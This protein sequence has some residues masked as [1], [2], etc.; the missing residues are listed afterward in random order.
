MA[1]CDDFYSAYYALRIYSMS[2][3][4]E[5]KGS[6]IRGGERGGERERELLSAHCARP[7][8]AKVR[9]EKPVG[10]EGLKGATTKQSRDGSVVSVVGWTESA[11]S[12]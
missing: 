11:D 1:R 10:G 12:A 8:V 4:D 3:F 9:G 7:C 2:I 6:G 5:D